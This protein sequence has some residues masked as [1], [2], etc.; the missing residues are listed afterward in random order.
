MKEYYERVLWTSCFE[1]SERFVWTSILNVFFQIFGTSF[2]NEY[3]ERVLF[4]FWTCIL[5]EF[6]E[7]VFSS[8][9][10]E[11]PERTFWTSCLSILGVPELN[12]HAWGCVVDA[13]RGFLGSPNRS[14][15]LWLWMVFL[16]FCVF[17]R[18]PQEK[19]IFLMCSCVLSISHKFT[20]AYKTW[21]ISPESVFFLYNRR[22]VTIT[23]VWM[24]VSCSLVCSGFNGLAKSRFCDFQ[25]S[26]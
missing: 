4:G 3:S 19:H 25:H 1:Y 14:I 8:I 23:I 18:T 15:V 21:G 26:L 20:F 5:N 9:L 17:L 13:S 22:R 6:S 10:N 12:K 7:R 11:Y 24:C 16:D 2:L